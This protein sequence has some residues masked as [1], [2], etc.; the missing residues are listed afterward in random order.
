MST[1]T[2]TV[3]GM[4]CGHCKASVEGEVGKV[5]GVTGVSVDLE[6]KVVTVE[7]SDLDTPAIVA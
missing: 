3:P 1:L 2:F 5:A 7:G 6:T 4:T